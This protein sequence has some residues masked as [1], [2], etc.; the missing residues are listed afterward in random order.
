MSMAGIFALHSAEGSLVVEHDDSGRVVWRHCGGRVAVDN[1]PCLAETRGPASF[2][3]D[4]DVPFAV[5]Q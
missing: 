2:S 4:R 5:A 3:L 1:V